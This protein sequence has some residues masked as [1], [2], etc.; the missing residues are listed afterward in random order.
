MYC[1]ERERLVARYETATREYSISV[2]S[3]AGKQSREFEVSYHE[4]ER[5]RTACEE[6]R[7]AL[8]RHSLQ[9][10]CGQAKPSIGD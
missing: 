2:Q 4:T 9:H 1:P 10:G 7:S 3:L 8:E 6:S 5:L